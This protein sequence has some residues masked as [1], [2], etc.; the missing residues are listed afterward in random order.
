[1][2]NI[3]TGLFET[4][5]SSCSKLIVPVDQNFSVPKILDLDDWPTEGRH[6]LYDM[7]EKNPERWIEFLYS[8]G[9]E[10]I[11]YAGP[12]KEVYEAIK[13]YKGITSN[14]VHIHFSEEWD[15]KWP[16]PVILSAI[17]GEDTKYYFDSSTEYNEPEED[18][19]HWTFI[20]R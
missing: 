19:K 6:Y 4:N 15:I 11:K 9:I 8:S 18:D 12:N 10:E 14:Q 7:V 3:R 2:I 13:T 5:S 17:F 16:R 20:W 1:M